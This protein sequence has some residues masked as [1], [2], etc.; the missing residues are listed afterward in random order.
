M[1]ETIR[2]SHP[3]TLDDGTILEKLEM[4]RP[5]VG[6]VVAANITGQGNQA[7]AESKLVA[8]LCGLNIEDMNRVDY[9]DYLKLQA[10]LL[11][12]LRGN[13]DAEA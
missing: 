6:D 7:A 11:R 5:T 3:V 8:R 2:L 12:F 10:V 4:R 1:K 9:A 13:D